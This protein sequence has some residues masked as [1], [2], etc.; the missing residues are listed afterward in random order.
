ML[1]YYVSL[2]WRDLIRQPGYGLLI[3][4]ILG[5]GVGLF[6]T[7]WSLLYAI[8]GDPIPKK[9]GRLLN[10]RMGTPLD[11]EPPSVMP[12]L[13][14]RSTRQVLGHIPTVALGGGLAVIE[15]VDTGDRPLRQTGL[16]RFTESG[17]FRMFDVPLTRGRIWNP[18]EEAQ[19]AP[20]A[21]IG[22]NMANT[23]FGTDDVVGRSVQL[24][25]THFRIIGTVGLW[26]PAPRYYDLSV[27]AYMTADDLY[28]PRRSL[29][30]VNDQVF[31][32]FTCANA[33]RPDVRNMEQSGCSWLSLWALASSDVKRIGGE[34]IDEDRA[35]IESKVRN[36]AASG[37]RDGWL[38]PDSVV[39]VENVQE[40]LQR[41]KVVPGGARY[42]VL[43][44][45]SFL[46]LCLINA[47]GLLLA[48]Y[49][50]RTQEIGVRRALGASRSQIIAQFVVD[51]SLMGTIG[52]VLGAFFTFIGIAV[53][54][55]LPG[56]YFQLAAFDLG[57]LALALGLSVL[58]GMLAGL[59]PA[60][61][62]S[63]VEPAIQVKVE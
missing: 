10:I 61:R 22:G 59:F 34:R 37:L 46:L 13:F 26:R 30:Y 27:G 17:F 31:L 48:K 32:T 38:P 15:G 6:M 50:R 44:A 41:M 57:V 18:E 60:W 19:G 16:L 7:T 14:V 52:S 24:G 55:H 63:G 2:A 62:A 3:A 12:D 40:L 53:V 21:L 8:S 4:A 11:G 23:L 9:S 28:L 51:A 25:G 33:T 29:R 39:K 5:F 56:F 45:A 42:G 47:A 35:E 49:L 54:R 1:S 43:I 20:V 36:L 58:A